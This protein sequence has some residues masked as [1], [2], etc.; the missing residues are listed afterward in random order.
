[1]ITLGGPHTCCALCCAGNVAGLCNWSE[2]MCRYHE[3]AKVVEPKIAA[4]H[5]AEAELKVATKEKNAAEE[6]MAKVQAKLDEM[7]AQ[8]DAAMAQK[9]VCVALVS[10]CLL[11]MLHVVCLCRG[12][13]DLA[14]AL[15]CMLACCSVHDE[16]MMQAL[17]RVHVCPPA[18]LQPVWCRP[19]RR[20]PL[21]ASARWTAPRRCCTRCLARRAAGPARARSLTARSCA[22]QVRSSCCSCHC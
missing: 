20:T 18:E 3:I 4:L 2:S 1:M 7:Q 17:W 14:G 22:S 6:R 16:I 10:C 12:D 11:V 13:L 5:A 19:W 9:Q 8:F 21:P 15:C